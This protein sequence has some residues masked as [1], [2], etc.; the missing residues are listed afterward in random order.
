MN[1]DKAKIH[2]PRRSKPNL[3][4]PITSD[5]N[6]PNFKNKQQCRRLIAQRSK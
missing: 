1:G 3:N 6:S 5:G 4:N 2:Q